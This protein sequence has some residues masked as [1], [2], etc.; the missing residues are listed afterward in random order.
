MDTIITL[1]QA[2]EPCL[3]RRWRRQLSQIA[4]AMVAMSGRVTMLG[5]ARWTGPGCS[6]RTIQRFF[7]QVQP[8]DAL[9]WL[10]FQA[11]LFDSTDQ[12]LLAGDEV[13]I[14][15]AGQA[16]HGIGRFFSTIYGRRIGALAFFNLS[17]VSVK[18]RR[19]YPLSA[20][21]VLGKPRPAPPVAEPNPAG[22][23]C[24]PVAKRKPGRPQGSKNQPR[25][26]AA[27]PPATPS[28][29][30][31]AKR[32]PGRPQGSKQQAQAA[33]TLPP[34]LVQIQCLIQ[35]L[36]ARL[37][38]VVPLVYLLLDGHWGNPPTVH[39]AQE[40]GLHLISKLHRNAALFLPYTGPYAG[41][42]PHKKYGDRVVYTALPE[43]YRVSTT[44]TDHIETHTYQLEVWH[45]DFANRLNV[46]VL[47]KR[48]CLTAAVAHVVLFSTDLTLPAAKL[49]DYYSLRFQIEFDFRDAKQFWGLDDFM[50]VTATAVTNA[51]NLALFMVL[52]SA[53]LLR[54]LRTI[55]PDA[56][57]LDLKANYRGQKYVLETIKLLPQKPDP[58]LLASLLIQ[59]TQLGAVH[60]RQ[61][62]TVPP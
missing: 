43:Q 2:T 37:A 22:A 61:T 11:H 62:H 17:L 28:A 3:S 24:P 20:T 13:V 49:V 42:G 52:L 60:K 26:T 27:V 54:D 34:E 21:Q 46:V 10:F 33:R 6:Y 53:R 5:L 8:W 57:I 35:A 38:N 25:T 12:Y 30:P 1:L 19:A 31:T 7:S 51:V 23:A 15:K 45:K 47:V 40:C 9:L 56:S 29:P 48:N 4:T 50:N 18:E 58:I 55:Q 39:L 36:Q 32:K 16:T 41:R 14:P 59:I 44:T